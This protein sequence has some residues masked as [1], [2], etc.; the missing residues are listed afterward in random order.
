MVGQ[1]DLDSLQKAVA[2]VR[3]HWPN[4]RPFLGLVL[5][6]G[7]GEVISAFPAG[8]ELPYENITALGKAAVIGHVGK[9]H[10]IRYA[11]KEILLFQG[12]RHWYE[13]AGWTPVI[14]P[15]FLSHELGAKMLLLTNAAGGINF[16]PGDLM[17][18]TDHINFL[19]AHPL[20]GPYRPQ[21]GERFPDQTHVYNPELVALLQRAGNDVGVSLKQGVYLA[22]SGPTY[23]TPADIRAY[24]VFGADA[25]G[26]S[27]VPEA[28]VGNALGMKIAAISCISNYAAGIGAQPLSSQEVLDTTAKVMPVMSRL[29]PR[30]V[31]LLAENLA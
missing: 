2:E 5:G 24:R 16:A 19:A 9:L 21:L 28:I 22:N 23:E 27:T 3:S 15:A 29:I 8:D 4:A 26:M 30:F 31:S 1:V 11:G 20:I 6:S 10:L 25:V 14:L 17:A 12:R 13:G 7:W 18:I